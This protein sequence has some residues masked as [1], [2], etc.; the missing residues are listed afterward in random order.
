MNCLK[1]GEEPQENTEE[2]K[3]SKEEPEV[4]AG[5]EGHMAAIL[6]EEGPQPETDREGGP[7]GG[8]PPERLDTKSPTDI[9][10]PGGTCFTLCQSHSSLLIMV[11]LLCE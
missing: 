5:G 6:E 7:E 4:V 9:N 1:G 10:Q 2:S 11:C 8:V 3:E